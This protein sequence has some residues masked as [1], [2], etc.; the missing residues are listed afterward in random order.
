M[1]NV[2]LYWIKKTYFI[3]YNGLIEQNSLFLQSKTDSDE[4]NY[5]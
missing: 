1:L 4:N 3:Q 5:T 2:V